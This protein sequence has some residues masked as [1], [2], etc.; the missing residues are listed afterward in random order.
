M[1]YRTLAGVVPP[2]FTACRIA[3]YK[4]RNQ[5]FEE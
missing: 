4:A 2:G 3:R 1:G 5:P